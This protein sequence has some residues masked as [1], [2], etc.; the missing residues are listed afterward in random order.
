MLMNQALATTASTRPTSARGITQEGTYYYVS[1]FQY[2]EDDFVYGGFEDGFWDGTDNVS[3]ELTVEEVIVSA[4][5]DPEEAL[6]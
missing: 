1:R 2:G 4:T 3:G 6:F 5:L